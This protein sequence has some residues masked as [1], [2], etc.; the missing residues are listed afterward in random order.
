[1]TDFSAPSV[2]DLEIAKTERPVGRAEHFDCDR[3]PV[4]DL[5]ENEVLGIARYEASVSKMDALCM[6]QASA[7]FDQVA[8][9]GAIAFFILNS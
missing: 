9:Q 1:V 3:K 8:R 5:T 4:E 7:R 2:W 6:P